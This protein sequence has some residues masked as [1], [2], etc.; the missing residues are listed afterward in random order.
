[1][2]KTLNYLKKKEN[3]KPQKAKQKSYSN[4]ITEKLDTKLPEK[5]KKPKVK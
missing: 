5:E 1:M 4:N 2:Q 3:I